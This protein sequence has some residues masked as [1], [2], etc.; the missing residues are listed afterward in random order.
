MASV[1][2]EGLK[3]GTWQL[4]NTTPNG[5]NV[6]PPEQSNASR[7]SSPH[8]LPCLW[9]HLLLL[10]HLLLRSKLLGGLLHLWLRCQVPVVLQPLIHG[11][12]ALLVPQS[13]LQ[14]FRGHPSTF[15]ALFSTTISA[16]LN[17][18]HSWYT[19]NNK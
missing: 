4:R 5:N 8:M 2:S 15:L 11:N 10:P 13:G 16:I 17:Q 6:E 7:L 12:G 18:S 14:N 19:I 9:N 1:I 3:H